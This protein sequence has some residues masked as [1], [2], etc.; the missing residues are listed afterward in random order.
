MS[1]LR[2][3]IWSVRHETAR[4]EELL[5][6]VDRRESL[7]RGELDDAQTL[8]H[9]QWIDQEHQGIRTFPIEILERPLQLAR[10]AYLY[11]AH[12]HAHGRSLGLD[13]FEPRRHPVVVRIP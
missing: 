1:D 3:D 12:V 11:R 13:L 8:A 7:F 5:D 9:G 2:I 4:V 10:V 6:L